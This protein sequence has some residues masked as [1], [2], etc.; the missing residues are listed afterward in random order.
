MTA[1]LAGVRLIELTNMLSGPYAGYLLGVLG[2]EVVKVELPGTGDISRQIGAEPAWNRR[3]MGSNFLSQNAGKKSITLNLKHPRAKELLK[4][5]VARADAV[6]E[7]FRP[8][9]LD[10]LGLGYDDLRTVRPGLVY[11]AI[12]GFGAEGPLRDVPAFDQIIQG[13]AGVMSVTGDEESAPLR[14]GF[15][16]SDTVAGLNAVI[17]VCAGLFR[18]RASGESQLVDV[19]MLDSTLSMMSWLIASYLATGLVPRPLGNE[20]EAACPSGAFRTADKVLNVAANTQPKYEALCGVLERPEL[21]TDPRFV[22]HDDRKAH[23][24]E[25]KAE[26]EEVLTRRPAAHWQERLTAAG[27]PAGPVLD[28]GEIM[29]HPQVAERRL[30]RHLADVPG[31]ERALDVI[32]PGFRT[33]GLAERPATPPPRL[34]EHTAELLAEL[35]VD[36]AELARLRA[37]GAV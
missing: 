23:R 30:V 9:V 29:A 10:R 33:A 31:L 20:N 8:G 1:P 14:V 17:G 18:A 32:G 7:N 15:P 34:G 35:G 36:A 19:S 3:D 11:C 16:V 5:L 28:I 22:T 21:L 13:M 2:A 6:L 25:M 27:V 12:S 26:L 37:E 24:L 4:G